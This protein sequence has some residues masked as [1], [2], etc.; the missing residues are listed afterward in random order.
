[1]QGGWLLRR[2]QRR[3]G[4]LNDRL[5]SVHYWTDICRFFP[6]VSVRQMG[7]HY[8]AWQF[9]N[10]NTLMASAHGLALGPFLFRADHLELE[11]HAFRVVLKPSLRG[12]G[13]RKSLMC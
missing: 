11:G 8:S 3:A 9:E 12:V 5:P 6:P 1:R 4:G 13:I 2:P 7:T 10:G